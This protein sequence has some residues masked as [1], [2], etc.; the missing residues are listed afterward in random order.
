MIT[1]FTPTYNRAK[2][3]TRLYES[4][5]KQTVLALVESP[6]EWIV[7][8]DGSTDDT[9]SLMQ[10]IIDERRIPVKYVY[11]ENGGK[12]TA[13]NR[14]VKEAKG[15]LFWILDSDDSLP[16]NA[17]ELLWKFLPQMKEKNA[18][19]ICGYMAHHTGEVIGHPVVKEAMWVSSIEMRYNLKI[20]GDM[21]EVF[22][23]S[24]LREEPFPEIYGEK[25]CPE[26]LV[27]F[28][29]AKRYKLLLIPEIIYYRDYLEGGLTDSIVKI[30]MNSPIATMMAYSE[31][32]NLN[33][34]FKNKI[35]HAINYWRF[36]FC[37]PY[38][39]VKIASW[40]N[41]FAL[42]GLLMH[43]NDKRKVIK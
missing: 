15:E 6:F 42:F 22:K 20:T 30:R 7:V 31:M 17:I 34:S 12:H 23:T 13:I 8:D 14:G 33:I 1:V 35:Y 9:K 36:A 3:L 43:L 21:M 40:G 28:R 25:F 38:R 32:F 18:G 29:I 11:K 2:L 16:D 39:V 4:L 26:V 24:V 27:W 5:C 10:N 41:L 19:G 37:A